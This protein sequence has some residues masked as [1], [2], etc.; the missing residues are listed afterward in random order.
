[1]W[2]ILIITKAENTGTYKSGYSII[3]IIT[4]HISQLTPPL[5]A[6]VYLIIKTIALKILQSDREP[7]CCSVLKTHI[8]SL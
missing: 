2:E 3:N 1:M 6:T 7:V 5:L 8:H 4:I